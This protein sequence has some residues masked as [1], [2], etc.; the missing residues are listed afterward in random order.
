MSA[1]S[2]ED[3]VN[4]LA[5]FSKGLEEGGF[6]DGRN[7]KIEYRWAY[8]DY[9]RLPGFAAEF[10]SRSVN[11][12]VAT[13]G[14]ASARAAKAATSAIPIV[15]TMGGDPVQAGLV[16]SFN[17]P[18]G[19]ATGC[20]VFTN[21]ME[22]KRL[23]LLREIVPGASLF[24]G[25]VNPNSPPAAGQ[26]R[27]IEEAARKTGRRLF[28][29]KASNDTELNAAF[30]ALLSERIGG[31]LVASDPFFDTR[32]GRIIAFAAQNRLPA[33]YQFREYAVEGGLISY[34]PSIT[35]A[36]RQAGIYAGRVLNGV[37]PADLP[38][39]GPTKFDFVINLKTAR[40]IG[41][42]IPPTLSARADEVIE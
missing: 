41:L 27:D 26:L 36:Y 34:G 33:I 14:D 3:T 6:I 15:F 13:G 7:V 10:V 22:A 24:G 9:D 31:L 12:L 2:P 5:A 29:A 35:E 28:I 23:D 30:A 39:Q 32:R 21:D 16:E 25:L 42:E 8:G 18:G 4:E 20:V 38:V 37:K 1:R 19:N 11:V 17:R 40:A